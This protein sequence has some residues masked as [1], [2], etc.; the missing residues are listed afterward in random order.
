MPGN[1]VIGGQGREFGWVGGELCAVLSCSSCSIILY[2]RMSANLVGLA[3]HSYYILEPVLVVA[4]L[5]RSNHD[6]LAGTYG[7]CGVVF[8]PGP[9]PLQWLHVIEP[10]QRCFAVGVAKCHV[11]TK[12]AAMRRD[13]P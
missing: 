7:R 2:P 9:W 8:V 13:K 6:I 4:R 10:I 11:S 5:T 3:C 1:D 12:D